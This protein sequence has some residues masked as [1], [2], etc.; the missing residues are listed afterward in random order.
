[1]A[2]KS[3][4]QKDI[5]RINERIADIYRSFGY[6][7]QTYQAIQSFAE[8]LK[9]EYGIQSHIASSGAIAFSQSEKGT[10]LSQQQLD[11]LLG[12]KTKGEQIKIIKQRSDVKL[13]N[14][15]AFAKA[16]VLN[17][18]HA[19][20]EEHAHE[21]YK[22]K[23]FRDV[24]KKKENLTDAEVYELINTYGD[25]EER[26]TIHDYYDPFDDMDRIVIDDDDI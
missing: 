16:K 20:I 11:R 18:L 26:R 14:E 3:K 7:N 13:T 12:Y 15:Q 9:D 4:Y 21:I 2:T 8:V 23:G 1:M 19:F 22:N 10:K 25:N 17:D 24:I 5:T 6:N